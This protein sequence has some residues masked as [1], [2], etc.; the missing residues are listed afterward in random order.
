METWTPT[1]VPPA[2]RRRVVFQ[3]ASDRVSWAPLQLPALFLELDSCVA[4]CT[5]GPLS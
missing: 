5:Q 2:L 3:D 4:I 1:L